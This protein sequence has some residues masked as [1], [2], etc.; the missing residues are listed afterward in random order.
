MNGFEQVPAMLG[1]MGKMVGQYFEGCL[2]GVV[3]GVI[4]PHVARKIKADATWLV[5][6]PA[7]SFVILPWLH[8]SRVLFTAGVVATVIAVPVYGCKDSMGEFGIRDAMEYRNVRIGVSLLAC[9][10][11]AQVISIGVLIV[12]VAILGGL[13]RAWWEHGLR[14]F[15]RGVSE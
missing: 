3:L 13:V 5:V 9:F 1:E 8:V 12:V 7:V 11:L 10:L 6:P 15:L 2:L 4:L 14:A